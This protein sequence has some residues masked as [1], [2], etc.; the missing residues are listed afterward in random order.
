M[1]LLK[2]VSLAVLSVFGIMCLKQ[3]KP[4]IVP[5]AS[6][7]VG[8]FLIVSVINEL[9]S[10]M[11][12]F[13]DLAT[14][15]GI[16]EQSITSVIKVIGI[17]YLCEFANGVC[18]DADCKSIGEKVVFAGKI[19]IILTALPIVMDIFELVCQIVK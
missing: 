4:E 19:A 13:Y 12:V 15:T 9:F 5:I 14:S 3:V 2:L 16:E 6:I 18:V 11:Y 17:G 1:E 10:L 7:A 8:V